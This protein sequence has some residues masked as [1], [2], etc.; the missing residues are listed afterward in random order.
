VQVDEIHISECEILDAITAAAHVLVLS[1]VCMPER[2]EQCVASSCRLSRAIALLPHAHAAVPTDVLQS[3]AV[4]QIAT[5]AGATAAHGTS[6][7]SAQRQQMSKALRRAC[8]HLAS[9][10]TAK[11]CS[12]SNPSKLS[13]TW[14]LLSTLAMRLAALHSVHSAQKMPER[15]CDAIM[16]LTSAAAGSGLAADVVALRRASMASEQCHA[17][18]PDTFDAQLASAL[19]QD[20]AGA[21]DLLG[22]LLLLLRRMCWTLLLQDMFVSMEIQTV[23]WQSSPAALSSSC[24]GGARALCFDFCRL[25]HQQ[26]GT[27]SPSKY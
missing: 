22:A 18:L 25:W 24:C 14:R 8:K 20:I 16:H 27:S 7:T 6:H 1:S 23:L 17:L 12:A 5:V 15:L 3:I 2:Q 21:L 13:P 9:M 26:P 19:E 4:A 10:L 11:D